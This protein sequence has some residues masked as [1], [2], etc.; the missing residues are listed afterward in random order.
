[1]HISSDR[2]GDRLVIRLAGRLDTT[3]A[4]T[5][6]STLKSLISGVTD[7]EIDCAGLVYISSAG[8]R[9]ILG[10]QKT[11]NTQGRM[12]LS[13]VGPAV[14]EVLTMTGFVDILTLV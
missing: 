1:M 10:A 7:L 8:L 5:L 4:P 9:V 13:Q 2:H 14:M 6:E 12:S 11:M 3:T